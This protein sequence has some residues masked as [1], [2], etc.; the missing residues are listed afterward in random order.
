MPALRPLLT[1]LCALACATTPL[2]AQETADTEAILKPIKTM[3]KGIRFEKYELAGQ[4]LHF[5]AMAREL[6]LESWSELTPEQQQEWIDGFSYLMKNMSF[7]KAH[8]KFE[9]LDEV[10]YD[11]P[12]VDGD[13]AQVGSTIVIYHDF[14]KEEILLSYTMLHDAGGWRVL[15][16]LVEEES[17]LEGIREDQV[18]ELMDDGGIELLLEKLREKVAEVRADVADAD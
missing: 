15:D 13:R 2:L 16:V 11:E 12:V 8:E 9:Y 6:F 14:K 18:E 3:I 4:S 5:E 17:T 7:R 10:F 1:L